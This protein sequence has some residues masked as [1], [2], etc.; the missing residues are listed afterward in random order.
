MRIAIEQREL[1]HH[2]QHLVGI[3]SSKTT[4]PILTNYLIEADANK[5]EVKITASDLEITVD[6][7]FSA[8]VSE[9][10]T[11]A[12]S[13]RHFNEIVSQMPPAV[14]DIWKTEDLLMIQ[15]SKIDFKILCADHSLF[16]ILPEPQMET[17]TRVNPETFNRMIGKTAFAVSTDPNRAVITGVC[18]KIMEKTNLMAATDGRK[19]AEIVVPNTAPAEGEEGKS[20]EPSIFSDPADE[21]IMERVI[22]VKTLNFLQKVYDPSIKELKVLMER[23]KIVLSYGSFTIISNIIDQKYPEY[24]KAFMADLPNQVIVSRKRLLESIRRVALVA[25]EDNNRIRFEISAENFEINTSNRDTG[26]AKE[27]VEEYQYTG[28]ETAVSFNYRFMVSILDVIDTE[29]VCIK[30]GSPKEPLM[31][32]NEPQPENQ[33]ITFLLMPLRS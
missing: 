4:S 19:V 5:G 6:V 11:I 23:S 32:Y 14:I 12:V 27:F 24:Q 30:L 25:P 29:K 8:A 20:T 16:P 28:A 2:I 21:Q 9:G 33:K 1:S 3:V 10:G 13:A 31:I 26:D 15:C 7:R 22:P 17:A 18:W